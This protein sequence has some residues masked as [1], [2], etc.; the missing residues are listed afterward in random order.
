VIRMTRD[1][2]TK[3]FANRQATAY[4][5]DGIVREAMTSSAD[6]FIFCRVQFPQLEDESVLDKLTT[7]Q[8]EAADR[9]YLEK[10]RL[11]N[12]RELS[13]YFSDCIGFVDDFESYSR[14][15]EGVRDGCTASQSARHRKTKMKGIHGFEEALQEGFIMGLHEGHISQ[16]DLND[17][18]DKMVA[19][20]NVDKDGN[21]KV[22]ELTTEA[23]KDR[24]RTR[25]E[26]LRMNSLYKR[27]NVFTLRR[28]PPDE[29]QRLYAECVKSEEPKRKGTST[30]PQQDSS[31]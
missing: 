3:G 19:D 18:V 21:S 1:L 28:P 10:V 11:R 8:K 24:I 9:C 17:T 22:G 15:P 23:L 13:T 5:A 14:S 31:D 12:L 20:A 6:A 7:G 30:P 2:R 25:G 4:V 26:G 27:D 16:T 29:E